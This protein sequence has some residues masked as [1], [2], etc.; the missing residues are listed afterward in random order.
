[1][2]YTLEERI[3]IVFIYGEEGQCAR[4]TAATFNERY[5]GKN[6]SH[7]Y[8][9]Q[10][11]KK[12]K[13]T[14]CVINKKTNQPKLINEAAQI[15]IMGHFAMNP[16]SSIRQVSATTGMSMG[17]VHKILKLNK[18]H[19][20][21]IQPYQKLLEED[22]DRRIQFCEEMTA[23]INVTPNLVQNICFSDALFL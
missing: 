14:G 17:S 8:V 21:K 15:E 20:Y 4:R 5:P 3:E 18:F 7:T 11:I 6:V 10:L 2:V 1:M 12:F 16:T 9:I 13:E 22:F 23:I 19:P